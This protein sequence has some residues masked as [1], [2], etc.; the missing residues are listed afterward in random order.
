VFIARKKVLA[1]KSKKG[2]RYYKN[3][4][5]GFKTPKTAITDNYVD[6]K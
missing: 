2:M 1:K 3:I 5:L 4:G 6:K